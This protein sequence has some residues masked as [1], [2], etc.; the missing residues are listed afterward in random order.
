ML[1]FPSK[2]VESM[3]S[4]GLGKRGVP[5]EVSPNRGGKGR[6]GEV[7]KGRVKEEELIGRRGEA[8]T[9]GREAEDAE[10]IARVGGL[11]VVL[12]S[13]ACFK[14]ASTDETFSCCLL[15]VSSFTSVLN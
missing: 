9:R 5:L 1:E 12:L 8:D 11:A 4:E 14:A 2:G 3:R 13:F 7:M 15:S 6:E 10:G